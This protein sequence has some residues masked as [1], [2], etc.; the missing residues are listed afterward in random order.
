MNINIRIGNESDI[1]YLVSNNLSLAKETENK[2]LSKDVVT[3]GVMNLLNHEDLGFYLIAE[4]EGQKV[5]SLMIT[6]EW[7]DWRNGLFWWIQSVYV[8]PTYRRQGIYREL[9]QYVKS[10][11]ADHDKVL[12][13]RLYAAK[14]NEIAI[15]TYETLGMKETYYNLFE[16]S[17]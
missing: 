17:K 1:D 3:E 9:Y 2:E 16:E 4:A 6:T 11:A 12:G 7:S 13:F 8:E 5:G 10:L 15:K 14:A